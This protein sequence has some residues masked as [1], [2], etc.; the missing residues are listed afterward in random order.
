LEVIPSTERAAPGLAFAATGT[1]APQSRENALVAVSSDVAQVPAVAISAIAPAP[2]ASR[3]VGGLTSNPVSRTMSDLVAPPPSTGV[4]GPI[5]GFALFAGVL[6]SG[7]VWLLSQSK[8]TATAAPLA[9]QPAPS[10]SSIPSASTA[11]PPTPPASVA[12]PTVATPPVP[13]SATAAAETEPSRSTTSHT[14]SSHSHHPPSTA[15]APPSPPVPVIAPPPAAISPAVVAAPPPAPPPP[16]APK[17]NPMDMG[18][19]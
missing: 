10:P 7:G 11:V 19:K 12:T 8:T 9:T 2:G 14:H 6:G 18:V 1:P 4:M 13:P 16:P 15:A 17:V 5:L 3:I